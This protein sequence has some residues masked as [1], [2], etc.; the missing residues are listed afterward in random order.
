MYYTDDPV[1][2]YARWDAE[3]QRQLER[4]PVCVDC[5]EHIEDEYFYLI[6]DEPICMECLKT[7]Y[8][9]STEDYIE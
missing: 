7:G 5:G 8:R 4:M 9:K 6:N 1:A 2:D 3:R